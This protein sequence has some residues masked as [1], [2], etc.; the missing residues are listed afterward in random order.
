MVTPVNNL[1]SIRVPI[2][3][4]P[5]NQGVLCFMYDPICVIQPG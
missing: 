3:K 2:G 1:V 4:N 5:I